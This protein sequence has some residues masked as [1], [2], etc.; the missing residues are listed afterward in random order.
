MYRSPIDLKIQEVTTISMADNLLDSKTGGCGLILAAPEMKNDYGFI[1]GI[2]IFLKERGAKILWGMRVDETVKAN[3]IF[4]KLRPEK[5]AIAR[6]LKS[7]AE[8][9]II[10]SAPMGIWQML[11][12]QIELN[13]QKGIKGYFAKQMSGL[14]KVIDLGKGGAILTG[15]GTKSL[16]IPPF[17]ELLNFTKDKILARDKNG[18]QVPAPWIDILSQTENITALASCSQWNDGK[19]KIPA[20]IIKTPHPLAEVLLI[21]PRTH[22]ILGPGQEGEFLHYNPYSLSVLE[23][24][25]PGDIGRSYKVDNYYGQ[26]FEFVRRLEVNE[27]GI[28]RACGGSMEEMMKA[29]KEGAEGHAE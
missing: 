10:L 8:P 6:F 26:G 12:G 3:S 20:S 24:F 27:G 23:A 13:K 21:D 29:H 28:D 7:N 22:K 1:F 16:D 4:E 18:N 14:G 2:E 25:F 11:K 19:L 15:G 9:K 17:D 5:K